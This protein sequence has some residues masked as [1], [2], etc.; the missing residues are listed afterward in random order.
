MGFVSSL[1][2]IANK[3]GGI[4]NKFASNSG[5]IG[6]IASGIG[7]AANLVST[8]VPK[9]VPVLNNVI[10]VAKLAYKSGL[11]DK[12]TN[13]KATQFVKNVQNMFSKPKGVVQTGAQVIQQAG[14]NTGSRQMA[15]LM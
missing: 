12:V 14:Q 2:G 13:G 5:I 10:G 9:A 4:A 1:L 8:I 15:N 7:K 11:M 3:V 6:K